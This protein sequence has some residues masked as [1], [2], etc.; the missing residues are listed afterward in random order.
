MGTISSMTH[1]KMTFSSL[2]GTGKHF[3]GNTICSSD[4]SVM[5]LICVLHFFTTNKTMSF[6]N[7]QKKKSRGDT[8]GE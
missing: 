2:P 4:D 1:I 7:P 5:Q 3:T 8:A 6:T